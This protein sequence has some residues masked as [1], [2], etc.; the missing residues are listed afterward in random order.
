MDAVTKRWI[1]NASDERAAANGYYFDER[2]G[3]HVVKFFERFLRLYE[4]DAAGQA[5]T[6]QDWQA[7]LLY[8][9]FGWVKEFAASV[10]SLRSCRRKTAR[11]RRARAWACTY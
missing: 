5:F 7:D 9:A 4:G 1:R 11:A 6:P 8:R 10:K 3:E 2:R